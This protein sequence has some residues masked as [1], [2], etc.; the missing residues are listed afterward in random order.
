M[1]SKGSYLLFQLSEFMDLSH[2]LPLIT[3]PA[4]GSRG[5]DVWDGRLHWA[6]PSSPVAWVHLDWPTSSDSGTASPGRTRTHDR[7][8][9][10]RSEPAERVAAGQERRGRIM[11]AV[12]VVAI[13]IV[14]GIGAITGVV[15]LVSVAS[16]RED[17]RPRSSRL[18]RE[19]PDRTTL[20]GRYL[21]Q[22]YVRRPGDEPPPPWPAGRQPVGHT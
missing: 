13:V 14:F 20:A 1:G 7:A 8:R 17:K 15:F 22:L 10:P 19:A 2:C 21:T 3:V 11:A 9:G 6:E 4:W 18:S 16:R 12:V 5:W